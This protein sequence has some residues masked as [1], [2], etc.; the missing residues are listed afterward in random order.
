MTV[1][2]PARRGACPSLSRP[3]QT[4]DGLIA[5]LSPAS[6]AFTARQLAQVAQLAARHGN[7]LLE[8]S[9]RG[10]LQV[11]GLSA[12]SAPLFAAAVTRAGIEVRRGIAIDISPLSGLDPQEPRDG[13]ALAAAVGARLQ[14]AP[15][16][17]NLAPKVSVVIDGGG[18]ISLA[19]LIG[20]LRLVAH[21]G[22]DCS[23]SSSNSGGE[24]GWLVFVGSIEAESICLGLLCGDDK[25][26]DAVTALLQR[27]ANMGSRA[28]GRDLTAADL[29]LPD[30]VMDALQPPPP[31]SRQA[32]NPAPPLLGLRR[33]RGGG[34][35][36]G[37]ALD[38]GTITA[39]RLS[40][41]A[42]AVVQANAATQIHAGACQITDRE[43]TG[44]QIIDGQIRFAPGRIM[45]VL[46]PDAAAGEALR[47]SAAKLGL[48]CQRD[49]PRLRYVTCAGAPACAS[50]HVQTHELARAIHATCGDL[51][52]EASQLPDG[53]RIHISGCSKRC[54]DPG[55]A[56]IDI[57]AGADGCSI[58]HN[59]TLQAGCVAPSDM[60]MVIGELVSKP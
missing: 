14:Q 51:L 24:S 5:R 10:N 20:D 36:A 6:G 38:L 30:H 13:R 35:V 25:A 28:R 45:L 33:L 58:F 15:W 26:A 48:I 37:F 41:F 21:G 55:G 31:L 56:M 50:A 57:I 1:I 49:D 54:A 60:P 19:R 11:R 32:S 23:S 34:F 44:G 47:S 53:G 2:P 16:S 59:G 27:L 29:V 7:G 17:Q 46:L 40:G 39:D 3:M 18:Q 43:I 4:G 22:G 42:N 9:L 8:V 12:S 52:H